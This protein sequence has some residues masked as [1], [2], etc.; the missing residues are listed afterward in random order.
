ML[1]AAN[2]KSNPVV[3]E[4]AGIG[5]KPGDA[6][7]LANAMQQLAAMP[8]AERAAMGSRGRTYV[9]AHHNFSTLGKKLADTLK[10]LD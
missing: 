5:L 9:L 4:N 3:A 1:Y 8:A 7:G 6:E 2:V 10:G